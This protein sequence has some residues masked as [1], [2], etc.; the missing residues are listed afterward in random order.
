MWDFASQRVNKNEEF[1]YFMIAYVL[2]TGGY[3]VASYVIWQRLV[4]QF[5]RTAGRVVAHTLSD[6]PVKLVPVA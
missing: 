5:E 1:T 6:E 3:L 4:Q 2:G